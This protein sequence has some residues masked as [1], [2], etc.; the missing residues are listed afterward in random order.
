MNPT[1][2]TA[3]SCS[4]AP[5]RAHLCLTN[6]EQDCPKNWH[7]PMDEEELSQIRSLGE[8]HDMEW[9]DTVNLATSTRWFKFLKSSE[10]PNCLYEWVPACQA[11]G[12][13]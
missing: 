12:I 3:A 13:A 1:A 5:E 6:I 7:V 11:M 8:Q 9:N 2:L 4:C 10:I